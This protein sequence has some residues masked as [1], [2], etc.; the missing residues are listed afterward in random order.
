MAE[1]HGR[2]LGAMCSH[3]LDDQL[4][5]RFNKDVPHYP[6]FFFF[7]FNIVFLS[8]YGVNNFGKLK[9]SGSLSHLAGLD[10]P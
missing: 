9:D 8:L 1:C 3:S 2:Q 10:L 6:V 4:V 5:K 7:F